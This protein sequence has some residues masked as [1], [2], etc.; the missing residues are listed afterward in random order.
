[1]KPINASNYQLDPLYPVVARAIAELLKSSDH[2]SPLDVLLHTQRVTKQQVEDWRFGRIPFLERVVVGNL[3]KMNR[4]L[5]IVDLH[6]HSLGLTA[7]PKIAHKWGRGG[8]RIVLR[9]S[10]SGDPGL[11]AAY[12]PALFHESRRASRADSASPSRRK[13]TEIRR[14]TGRASPAPRGGMNRAATVR[15]R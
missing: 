7:V 10:K 2:F 6:A 5:R 3:S 15:E 9:F 4:L 11:E 8:K 12:F 13:G 14:E 1:M